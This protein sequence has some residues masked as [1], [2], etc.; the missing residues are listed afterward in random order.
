MK[1]LVPL[2]AAFAM[3]ALPVANV[4][5]SNNA[6][7]ELLPEMQNAVTWDQH[8]FFIRGERAMLFSGEVHPFRLPVPSLYLDVFQKIKALGFNMVSFYPNWALLEGKPGQY[9]GTGIFDL[10]PFFEAAKKAGIY[11]LA[12]PG[13]YI[14]AEVSGGGFPGWLQRINGT[15][16]TD[17]PEFLK[18]TENYM[19]NVCQTIAKYQITNGGPIVLFQPENEYSIG[20]DIPFPNGKYM[21][22]IIHQARNAG[23]KV[24]MINNDVAPLGYYAP[25]TGLGQMDI[26]GHDSYP[27]GFNCGKPD[28]WPPGRL[29]TN[30]HQLHQMQSP[31]TPYS[32][33]EFQGGSFDAWGG[34]GLDKCY[35]LIN[36][37]FARVFNKNNFAAGVTLF[38]IYMIFGGTNWGNIGH[39]GGYTSYDYG[40]CIR[41]NRAVDREKYSEVKL[42]AEFLKVS[43]GYLVATPAPTSPNIVVDSTAVTATLLHGNRS[44]SFIVVR[45]TDYSSTASVS[46]RLRLETSEMSL[47]VPQTGGMLTLSGRD[48]KVHLVDY[49]VGRHVLLYSTCEV[50]TWK[51][52]SSKTVLI[53]YGGLGETHEFAVKGHHDDVLSLEGQDFSTRQ[54]SQL[55]TIVRWAV[56]SQRSVLQF[57]DLEV[58]LVDRNA[59][60]KYWVPVLQQQ[61][62][63]YGTSLMNPEAVI[64][65]GGYLIRSASVAGSTLSLKADFNTSTTLEIIGSPPGVCDLEINGK[66]LPFVLN[67]L[68]NW[69]VSPRVA[70]LKIAVPDLSKLHWHAIDSLPEVKQGYDDSAWPVANRGTSD[71]SVTPLKTPVSLYASDYGFNAGTLVFRGHFT[72]SGTESQFRIDTAGGEAYA[73]SVWLN[74]TFLGS[75]KNT[76]AVAD[77]SATYALH[78]LT[79]G[80]HYVFTVVVDNM[81]L[82]EN[83][84]PGWDVMKAPRG[85]LDYALT[86]PDG[87]QTPISSWKIT[88]NFGA[89]DYV[90][91]S[92]GPLNEGGFFFERLGLHLPDPPLAEAPF[93]PD[94]S[95]FDPIPSPG[96]SF[97]VAKMPLS[98]PSLSHD[99][100]L[101]FVFDNNT[102]A[103]QRSDYRAMLFVNGFQYG[104]YVSNIGPQTEFPVP[105]GI[106]DYNG[107][108]W[109][110]L[111]IWALDAS[112]LTFP[113]LFLQAGTAVQTA[114]EPVEVVR[115]WPYW[116]RDGA[117]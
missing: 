13:P 31:N 80:A 117:Y 93:V 32:I 6:K 50:F 88:G 12:R 45:H 109:I 76:Q 106:L 99:V 19:R 100:P 78:K 86:S 77:G 114:R 22:Y 38:S 21:Q 3:A 59:A 89:E 36:H 24:P 97:F 48:S 94:R 55:G 63:A 28:V 103:T 18:A 105:E 65:N 27:L 81:G 115:A 35:T 72:A 17:S 58:Y 108:N 83:Y 23:I 25:G 10:E 95:P 73:T 2:S 8:S 1:L 39:P 40:A 82:N 104:R 46:Y 61:D 70:L 15:L 71:N 101:S 57:Q 69:L 43:P 79:R 90:D 51:Q 110:G 26:Y 102:A 92:R 4:T 14:N 91:L 54:D 42:E 84:N 56:S 53:L 112:G 62:N 16:R 66:V 5:D 85:I 107:D 41:E 34:H 87:S 20:H 7:I 68:G 75:F 60:Y 113:G 96:V 29:P 74:D 44:G 33:I 11:L 9:R 64:I 37:E 30:F 116:R 111:A 49:P 67:E 52:F 98:L 47:T